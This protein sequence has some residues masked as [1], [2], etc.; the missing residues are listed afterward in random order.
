MRMYIRRTAYKLDSEQW[1]FEEPKTKRSRRMV[2]L[3]TCP[4]KL[5]LSYP[6]ASRLAFNREIWRSLLS[7]FIHKS[8][9]SLLQNSENMI[10]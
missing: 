6:R 1:R 10:K 4:Q 2:A 9:V 5:F 7:L 8:Y 3:L